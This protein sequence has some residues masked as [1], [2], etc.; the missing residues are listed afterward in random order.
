MGELGA[1][2][3]NFF[4]AEVGAA[5]ALTGLI[6]VAVS[7]NL[8]RILEFPQ[9]PGR[10]A[11][12]LIMLVCA[13]LVCSLGLVPGQP[14]KTFGAE[15]LGAGLLM[16]ASP[17]V[18]QARQVTVLKTQPLTWWLYRHLITLVGGVPVLIGGLYLVAGTAD[19]LYW[20]AAG[21]LAT[22]AGAVWNAW[23]L[24]VEILR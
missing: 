16:T 6:I 20:M 24:L 12:V 22:L 15:V 4:I 14:L 3:A 18:I 23:V 2:W 21:V 17:M 7:I 10:A 1:A 13:L 5:A 8:Q 9:L 11:E 19:G